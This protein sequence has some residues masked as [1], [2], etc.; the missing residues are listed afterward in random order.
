MVASSRRRHQRHLLDRGEVEV[1]RSQQ[2]GDGVRMATGGAGEETE[3]GNRVALV[4]LLPGQR[5][6]LQQPERCR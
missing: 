2:M 1:D 6:E 5:R 4:G 3:D